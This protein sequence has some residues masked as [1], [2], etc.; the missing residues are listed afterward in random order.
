[1]ADASLLDR[2]NSGGE[3][4]NSMV[5][6]TLMYAE[7]TGYSGQTVRQ[8]SDSICTS[9][10]NNIF[11]H[12]G[13]SKE[14]Y[15]NAKAVQ[16][17]LNSGK[18]G[19]LGDYVMY[20]HSENLGSNVEGAYGAAF[21]KG[22]SPQEATDVIVAFRG[23]GDG[24]WNDNGDA[25]GRPGEGTSRS[26]LESDYQRAAREYFDQ[27]MREMGVNDSTNLIVTGHSKGGNLAQYVT[28]A[29]ALRKYVDKTYSIDGQGFS[30]EMQSYMESLDGF[31]E[32]CQKLY[33]ICGDNDYVNVL[34]KKVIP[35]EHTVY[36]K[37]DCGVGDFTNSHALYNSKTGNGNLFDFN[38]EGFNEPTVN[39]R[40]LALTADALSRKIME[41]DRQTR[42]EMSRTIMSALE[43][44]LGGKWTGLK[45]EHAGFKDIIGTIKHIGDIVE[46]LKQ[47]DVG[48]KF[49]DTLINEKL[50]G[51]KNFFDKI[52]HNTAVMFAVSVVK[53]GIKGIHDTAVGIMNY[54]NSKVQEGVSYIV[55]KGKGF[56]DTLRNFCSGVAHTTGVIASAIKNSVDGAIDAIKELLRD[57]DTILL[58][59]SAFSKAI[60]D[61][62]ALKSE[63]TSLKNDVEAALTALHSGFD[64]PAGDVFMKSCR[65]NL[66]EPITREEEVITSISSTLEQVQSKYTSVFSEYEHLTQSIAACQR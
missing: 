65:N 1:M 13:I 36:I 51:V 45:G 32:Q 20:N 64:T 25:F 33:S 43:I 42:G 54:V 37:T 26:D 55:E 66:L 19:D 50:S 8:I 46:V 39:Q 29:S 23:T 30:P 40:E 4:D 35:E 60:K 49:L 3:V 16:T 11:F 62:M 24:R 48:K 15:E 14:Q 61:F 10:E 59:E 53:D 47:P 18:A 6:D 22:D 5:L 17:Y 41:L 2:I 44:A 52:F 27:T 21:Y 31:K 7:P 38:G 28:L 12:G 9:Y 57:H 58:D 63:I 34:G 56:I